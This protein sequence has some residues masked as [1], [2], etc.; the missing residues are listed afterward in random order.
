MYFLAFTYFRCFE[1]FLPSHVKALYSHPV[2][3]VPHCAESY[4]MRFLSLSKK[5]CLNTV[6][7]SVTFQRYTIFFDNFFL[8]QY[9]DLHIANIYLRGFLA[10]CGVFFKCL[11]NIKI[12]FYTLFMKKVEKKG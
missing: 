5:I 3:K 2:N 4:F 11:G 1:S 7:K 6:F 12:A 9:F 8:L 10:L